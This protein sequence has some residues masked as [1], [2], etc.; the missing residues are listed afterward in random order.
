MTNG[1]GTNPVVTPVIHRRLLI[2][3][4]LAYKITFEDSLS[5]L[6]SVRYFPMPRLVLFPF[7]ILTKFLLSYYI[8]IYHEIIWRNRFMK[9]EPDDDTKLKD[10]IP[11]AAYATDVYFLK[12]C[13]YF[14]EF[15][16]VVQ[17]HYS[18]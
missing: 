13:C 9:C 12:F 5:V 11:M 3:M 8:I 4:I 2:L 15:R 14:A 1:L 18:L 7:A 10:L 6:T 17:K 16:R